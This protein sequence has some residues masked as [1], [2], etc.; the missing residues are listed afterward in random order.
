MI[1]L[2]GVQENSFN[3]ADSTILD[4]E[5]NNDTYPLNNNEIY[6]QMSEW[7][8]KYA[9]VSIRDK[10]KIVFVTSAGG[11]E[12]QAQYFKYSAEKIGWE[13]QV[14]FK[15]AKQFSND[16][17]KFDPDFILFSL[18]A[19][20]DF[21]NRL[22]AHHSKKYFIDLSLIESHMKTWGHISKSDIE[23]NTV[24]RSLE[25]YLSPFDG[26]LDYAGDI[27]IFKNIFSK[28]NK[29]F[30]GI[31]CLPSAPALINEPAEPEYLTWCGMGWDKFRSSG[32]FKDFI[33]RLSKSVAMKVYGPTDYLN[34]LP[35]ESYDGFTPPGI[36]HIEAIRKNG[37][38]LLTHTDLHIEY[39]FPTGRIF[40]ALAANV[41]IISDKNPFVINNF[42]DNILYYD[43]Y[44]SNDVMCQ[45]VKDHYDWIKSNP[46]KA[47]AMAG[48]AH[49][50][51]LDRFTTEKIL[52]RIAKMH[53]YIVSK[54]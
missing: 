27:N 7:D 38:Y 29:T 1:D 16:I 47:K 6:P 11:E 4:I 2:I 19:S 10:Y 34:F 3:Y 15:Y 5:S 54:S 25:S 20:R 45:Q 46:E 48:R 17:I 23:G 14:Y 9:N 51:F 39:G 30:E 28:I 42:G 53:E 22:I 21:G 26:M 24:S 52:P 36:P 49:Q 35:A 33:T 50:I 40:E 41:I 13:A 44:A 32:K 18:F 12:N 31:D 37:I 8:M 43:Q